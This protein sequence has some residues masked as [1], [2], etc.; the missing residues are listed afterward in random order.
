MISIP[1]VLAVNMLLITL[2]LSKYQGLLTQPLLVF[3]FR[4]RFTL[5]KV[6][7]KMFGGFWWLLVGAPL[8]AYFLAIFWIFPLLSGIYP[9]LTNYGLN[10][11]TVLNFGN[12]VAI[13]IFL[14]LW[15]GLSLGYFGAKIYKRN[16]SK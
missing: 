13:L 16:G 14:G 9:S 7:L 2:L 8:A 10:I 4:S 5:Q 15:V 6:G 11:S 1:T 12:P 3:A